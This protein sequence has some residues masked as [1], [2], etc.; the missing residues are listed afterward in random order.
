MALTDAQYAALKADIAADP[1]LTSQPNNPD[2]HFLIAREYNKQATPDFTVWRT[3]VTITEIG[4]S[5]VGT[6]VANL[7][8]ANVSRLQLIFAMSGDAIDPSKND[9]R[10]FFDDIFSGT[11][12]ANTRAALLTLWKRL[13]TRAEKLF[14]N[15]NGGDGS[16]ATPARLRFEGELSYQDVEIARALP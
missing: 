1:A 10:K 4:D 15:I 11:G 9:R 8:T 14:A 2:G 16:N 3:A 5:M 7:T 13:A 12:G 6:E